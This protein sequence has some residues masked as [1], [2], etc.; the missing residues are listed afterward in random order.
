M[1]YSFDQIALAKNLQYLPKVSRENAIPERSVLVFRFIADF[2]LIH[3]HSGMYLKVT[4][5]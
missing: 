3:N 5:N 4:E 2:Q 1:K